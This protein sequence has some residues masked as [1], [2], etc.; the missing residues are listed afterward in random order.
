MT[1]L[2]L[3]QRFY[4]HASRRL[5]LRYWREDHYHA[6]QSYYIISPHVT[7]KAP[8]PESLLVFT[9][10]RRREATVEEMAIAFAA[11]AGVTITPKG[12]GN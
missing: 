5:P 3:A 9:R 11:T 12:Q 10:R 6:L 4:L 2:E 1:S 7:K 8:K